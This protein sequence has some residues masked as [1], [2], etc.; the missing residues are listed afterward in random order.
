MKIKDIR[1]RLCVFFFFYFIGCVCLVD[2]T[3][4]EE[5]LRN[6]IKWDDQKDE[7]DGWAG[8]GMGIF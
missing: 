3:G 6:G 7:V 5:W 1:F 4:S 8:K 2:G